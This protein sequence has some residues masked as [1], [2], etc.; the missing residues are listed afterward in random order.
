MVLTKELLSQNLIHGVKEMLLKLHQMM[1]VLEEKQKIIYMK[2]DTDGIISPQT[3]LDC[4]ELKV[5]HK[6]FDNAFCLVL[7]SKA[8]ANA[9]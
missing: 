4:V 1:R 6:A 7:E 9:Y 2:K 8:E 5:S 3:F